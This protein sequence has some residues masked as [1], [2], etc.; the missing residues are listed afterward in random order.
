M[1]VNECVHL[2]AVLQPFCPTEGSLDAGA[3]F[4][5]VVKSN[6]AVKNFQPFLYRVLNFFPL[7][8][9]STVNLLLSPCSES[10][11]I[12]AFPLFVNPGFNF[13]EKQLLQANWYYF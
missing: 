4:L 7:C 12:N 2:A 10:F 6:A 1:R 5:K 11:R 3:N 13:C 9:P 8:L